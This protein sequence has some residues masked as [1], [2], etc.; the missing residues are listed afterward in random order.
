MADSDYLNFFKRGINDGKWH[1]IHGGESSL[2]VMSLHIVN[3]TIHEGVFTLALGSED[4]TPTQGQDAIDSDGAVIPD[5]TQSILFSDLLEPSEYT[6]LDVASGGK[7]LLAEGSK[8]AVAISQAD[9]EVSVT[10]MKGV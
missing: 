5:D 8:L 3:P 2:V 4:V 10:G 7:L 9:L 6:Y 1:I